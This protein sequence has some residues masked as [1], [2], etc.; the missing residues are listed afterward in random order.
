MNKSG[1]LLAAAAVMGLS[2]VSMASDFQFEL[3]G[4][5]IDFQGNSAYGADLAWHF[6]PVQRR[7]G[8]LDQA[9]F[10]NRSSNL[11]VDYLRD[12]DGAFDIY[13]GELELY[14]E[15]FYVGLGASRFSNGFDIDS[16]S[17][18][19]GWMTGRNTR[20]TGG[21]D[22][23]DS[24]TS[25][26]VDI[27]SVG[28]KHVQTLANDRAIHFDGEIGTITDDV[29]ELTHTIQADFYPM[30]HFGL[31]LR[32]SGI[33]SDHSYGVGTRFF[34]TPRISGGFEWLHH[35]AS[36]TDTYQFRVAARF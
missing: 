29:S 19:A 16:Y 31:G 9:G 24:P 8:P 1:L 2:S 5:L 32:S 4:S 6:E 27:L 35:D 15:G 3:G 28:I 20:F 34:F 7:T 18:R 12:T 25:S 14:M 36:D 33:G 23:I 10:I 17:L 13:G 22:H 11:R 21:W 30:S 26:G